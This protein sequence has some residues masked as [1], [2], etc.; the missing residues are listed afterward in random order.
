MSEADDSEG[1]GGRFPAAAERLWRNRWGVAAAGLSLVAVSAAGGAPLAALAGFLVVAAVTAFDSRGG[2]ARVLAR[3]DDVDRPPPINLTAADLIASVRDPL[4]VVDQQ[5]LVTESNIAARAAF[6]PLEPE[7]PLLLRFRSPE[8]QEFLRG[9]LA[10]PDAG[11]QIDYIER[12]P[13]ERLFRL[14]A[15]PAGGAGLTVLVF[16]DQSETRRIDRMRADFVANASHE[17]RTP[18]ASIAGFIETLR[19]PAKNDAAARENFLQIMQ[20]QTERMARLIDDLL[21]LSRLE[22]KALIDPAVTVDLKS[23][24]ENVVDA[25][26]PLAAESGVSITRRLPGGPALVAG[27]RDELFQVF[28]NLLENACKYG[29]SGGA[30]VVAMQEAGSG[31]DREILVTVE[32][33]GPGIA[34]EHIP[35]LTERFYRVEAEASSAQKGTGLGLAI[36]KHILTRHN[37]HLSVRSEPGKGSAF[38]VHLP[39]A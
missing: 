25:L 1:G 16:R 8:M 21:S 31:K 19:G 4:V 3:P 13:V 24:V 12:V 15:T 30:A 6:G 28:E 11:G 7:T 26:A 17:L 10:R 34:E 36:V 2:F 29:Q 33:F 18:L 32:D 39:A 14:S 23:I 22:M 37:G 9:V 27:S 5:G 38:T 35:R 20:N